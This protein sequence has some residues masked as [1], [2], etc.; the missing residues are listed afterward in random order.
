MTKAVQGVG[1]SERK[2]AWKY[3]REVVATLCLLFLMKLHKTAP[4]FAQCIQD[5]VEPLLTYLVEDTVGQTHG[6]RMQ[7]LVVVAES[8][9]VPEAGC[10]KYNCQ[11]VAYS[12][13]CEER[14]RGVC[15]IRERRRQLKLEIMIMAMQIIAIFNVN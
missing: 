11:H 13:A 2:G 1:S 4:Q 8:V 15:A 5:T 3:A 7:G 10:R 14:E 12:H 6:D 9:H